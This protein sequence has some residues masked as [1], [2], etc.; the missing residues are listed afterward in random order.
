MK[1]AVGHYDLG[2]SDGLKLYIAL[3]MNYRNRVLANPW[4]TEN[5]ILKNGAIFCYAAKPSTTCEVKR[6]VL[7]WQRESASC[8]LETAWEIGLK[9]WESRSSRTYIW[10]SEEQVLQALDT[11]C[12]HLRWLVFRGLFDISLTLRIWLLL[13]ISNVFC[14][15]DN[16]C[17]FQCS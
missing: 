6:C 7:T 11:F 15:P 10:W 8:P 5:R 4:V 12:L 2:D 13:G 17:L 9:M 1:Q 14:F 16:Q 3:Q